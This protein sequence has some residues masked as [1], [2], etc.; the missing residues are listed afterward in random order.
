[1]TRACR[2]ARPARPRHSGS[3][4]P[5]SRRRAGDTSASW[6]TSRAWTVLSGAGVRVGH[7]YDERL[8]AFLLDVELGAAG[9]IQMPARGVER[10]GNALSDTAPRVDVL[11]VAACHIPGAH[12]LLAAALELGVSG[13]QAVVAPLIA[14]LELLPFDADHDGPGLVIVR[15]GAT[16]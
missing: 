1:G 16:A 4:P 13:R 15:R 9:V 2:A 10:H 5:P 11:R 3:R 12:A 6:G 8:L 14:G 7:L